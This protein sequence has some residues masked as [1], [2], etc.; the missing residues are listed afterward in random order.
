M[1]YW[2]GGVMVHF[3]Q[4]SYDSISPFSSAFAARLE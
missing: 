2:S 1:E 4:T 3:L